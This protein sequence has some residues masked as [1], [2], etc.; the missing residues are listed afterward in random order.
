MA[1][2]RQKMDFPTWSEKIWAKIHAKLQLG[3]F[4]KE[5]P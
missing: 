4:S 5:T 1:V 3:E 2:E